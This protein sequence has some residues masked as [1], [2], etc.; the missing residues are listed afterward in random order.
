MQYSFLCNH[1]FIL[2]TCGFKTNLKWCWT[3]LLPS[4]EVCQQSNNNVLLLK[5]MC[6]AL[7]SAFRFERFFSALIFE[8]SPQSKS[9]ECVHGSP[10]NGHGRT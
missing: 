2:V 7:W 1:I 9:F 8:P 6:W 4:K 5:M 10:S 3:V